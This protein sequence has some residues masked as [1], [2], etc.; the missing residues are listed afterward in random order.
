ME[1]QVR[2]LAL[3]HAL[4]AKATVPAL[5]DEPASGYIV[6]TGGAGWRSS[7]T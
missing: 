6:V 3:S 4:F 7:T 1:A 5:R 2:N